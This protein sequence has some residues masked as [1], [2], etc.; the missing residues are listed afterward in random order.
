MERSRPLSHHWLSP[1][2]TAAARTD[3][4]TQHVSLRRPIIR[5]LGVTLVVLWVGGCATMSPPVQEMSDARQAVRAT[6]VLLDE[7]NG[8]SAHLSEA[9]ILLEKA[10]QALAEGRYDVA[11]E[12]AKA[13]K[14]QAI[15]A[16][17]MSNIESG[18]A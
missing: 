10:S 16:R 8:Q 2:R 1:A 15:R 6:R 5:S 13:A 14:E 7:H 12:A 3:E 17:R 18:G 9:E 11:R 4:I